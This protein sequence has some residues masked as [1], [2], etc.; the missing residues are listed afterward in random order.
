MPQSLGARF[1]VK[2]DTRALG[3]AFALAGSRLEEYKYARF[4]VATL[5]DH[6]DL[7]FVYLASGH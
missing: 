1:S 7:A 6:C 3:A 5:G 4:P 2:E